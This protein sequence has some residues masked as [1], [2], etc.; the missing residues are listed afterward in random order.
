MDENSNIIEDCGDYVIVEDTLKHVV[1]I[2]A[3][4]IPNIAESVIKGMRDARKFAKKFCELHRELL[5]RL[6]DR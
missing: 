2:D 5:K 6:A 4:P 3:P 1:I